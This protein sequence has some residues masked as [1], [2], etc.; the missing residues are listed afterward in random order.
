LNVCVFLPT[1]FMSLQELPVFQSQ[2]PTTF[3]VA[4]VKSFGTTQRAL[5]WSPIVVAASPVAQA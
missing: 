3:P 2:R 5:I 1:L 4:Q